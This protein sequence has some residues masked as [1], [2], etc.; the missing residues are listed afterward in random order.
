MNK[1]VFGAKISSTLNL[2][3]QKMVLE[4]RKRKEEKVHKKEYSEN[5]LKYIQKQINKVM[6]QVRDLKKK[7]S[8]TKSTEQKE[9]YNRM[10]LNLTDEFKELFNKQHQIMVYL[11]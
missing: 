6:K 8:K 11:N 9:I 2:P 4:K 10:I 3:N 5:K 7:K 1:R